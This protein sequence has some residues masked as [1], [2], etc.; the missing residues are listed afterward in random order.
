MLLA[1]FEAN[2]LRNVPADFEPLQ[3]CGFDATPVM[4]EDHTGAKL[5]SNIGDH[6]IPCDP[7]KK[8]IQQCI[9]NPL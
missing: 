3:V 1:H 7:W 2:S 6:W 9:C 5:S 4:D 8:R